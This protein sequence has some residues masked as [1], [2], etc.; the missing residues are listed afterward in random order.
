MRVIQHAVRSVLLGSLFSLLIGLSGCI[1]VVQ[2]TQIVVVTHTPAPANPTAPPQPTFAGP[3]PTPVGGGD[4]P[5]APTLPAGAE[6]ASVIFVID[7]DTIDVSIEGRE[8][9]V[10]YISINTPERDEPCYDEAT[11]ANR[12]LVENQ[13]VTLVKDVSERDSYGRLLRYVYIGEV[14]VNA[15]LVADGWAEARRY[16]PDTAQYDYL[17]SLEAN[18]AAQNLG[19]WAFGVFER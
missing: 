13:I 7:G 6:Y 19:C 10:R 9:R 11:N 14:F 18:A 17:D 8:E 5:A 12:I 2:P 1:T 15:Q 16:N 4:A 3:T